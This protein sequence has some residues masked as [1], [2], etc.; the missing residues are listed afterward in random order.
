MFRV[1]ELSDFPPLFPEGFGCSTASQRHWTR[2]CGDVRMSSIES[3]SVT[4]QRAALARSGVWGVSEKPQPFRRQIRA[5]RGAR[6]AD[7]GP[8]DMAAPSGGAQTAQ[9]ARFEEC[10]G[11]R[12][13]GSASD[14]R[15]CSVSCQ[16]TFPKD[17][18]TCNSLP[19]RGQPGTT[20]PP[21]EPRFSGLQPHLPGTRGLVLLSAECD[22]HSPPAQ[23]GLV[24][25]ACHCMWPRSGDPPCRPARPDLSQF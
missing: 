12:G 8:L 17:R 9:P 22:T 2:P 13:R 16:V 6:T 11:R 4:V 19:R 10:W 3:V 20:W 14:S 18:V 15:P 23:C 25:T 1:P 24:P 7:G 21:H 5:L